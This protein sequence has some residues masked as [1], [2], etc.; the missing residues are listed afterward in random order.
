MVLEE[1]YG[2]K[3]S[4]ILYI[5]GN[6]EEANVIMG[7]GQYGSIEEYTNRAKK[8]MERL[9]KNMATVN[10]AIAKF[11]GISLK[12]TKRIIELNDYFWRRL[13]NVNKVEIYGHSLGDIDIPYFE[14][15]NNSIKSD[16]QW[17]FYNYN[18]DKREIQRKMESFGVNKEQI[19]ICSY[20]EF[21]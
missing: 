8:A 5:H 18:S 19:R 9:D 6:V 17:V 3:S 16:S 21:F 14:K 13:K 20:E 2:I 10:D 11:Y 7:H 1:I 4:N 15:V 12:D